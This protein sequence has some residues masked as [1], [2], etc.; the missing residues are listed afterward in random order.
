MN[1]DI[2]GW[3][4]TENGTH[5]PIKKGQSKKEAIVET[6]NN[7]DDL[8]KAGYGITQDNI[9]KTS[10]SDYEKQKGKEIDENFP[11][12]PLEKYDIDSQNEH[13]EQLIK[14]G[15]AKINL[16][17]EI[18]KEYKIDANK[19]TDKE[20]QERVIKKSEWFENFANSQKPLLETLRKNINFRNSQKEKH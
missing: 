18:A 4:S 13:D 7:R 5:I 19:I 12:K 1:N 17:N 20:L 6:F 14:N 3:F 9:W 15:E 16:Y 2:V 8:I 10:L 11:I